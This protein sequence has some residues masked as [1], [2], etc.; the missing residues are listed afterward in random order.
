MDEYVEN[1]Q[2]INECP[3]CR[4]ESPL[5]ISSIPTGAA[6]ITL[7]H[8]PGCMSSSYIIDVQIKDYK[9]GLPGYTINY[10]P[11]CGRKLNN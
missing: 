10:C 4:D 3:Y 8:N 6:S 1:S 9:I 2:S 5:A 7:R 11:C